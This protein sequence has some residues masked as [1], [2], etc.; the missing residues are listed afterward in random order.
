MA[1]RP[2]KDGA[3]VPMSKPKRAKKGAAPKAAASTPARAGD[4][5]AEEAAKIQCFNAHREKLRPLEAKL[6]AVKKQISDAYLDAKRDKFHKKLFVLAKDMTGTRKQEEKVINGV[7]DVRFVAKALGLPIANQLDFFADA[8]TDAGSTR[9][10]PEAEGREQ[11]A[12]GKA[13]KPPYSP[14]TKDF[15]EF[16]RGFYAAQEDATRS[17]IKP[18]EP[19]SAKARRTTAAPV[20]EQTE[21][22]DGDIDPPW[23]DDVGG[24]PDR[25]LAQH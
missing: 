2:K 5:S 18:L 17:G 10:S 24:D 22:D 3:N 21:D 9:P 25:P 11:Y 12:S 16:M 20:V 1:K 8:A 4:T 13:A 15:D 14:G 19:K 23:P 6:A 7:K